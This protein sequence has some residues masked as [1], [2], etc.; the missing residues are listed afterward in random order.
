MPQTPAS[1]TVQARESLALPGNQPVVF[2]NGCGRFPIAGR[3]GSDSSAPLWEERRLQPA[4]VVLF[5]T[6]VCATAFAALC[7]TF[8]APET[9]GRWDRNRRKISTSHEA[10]GQRYRSQVACPKHQPACQDADCAG[11]SA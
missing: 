2:L 6:I 10:V 1:S 9:G 7:L 11:C 5:R 3:V 8:S 4:L